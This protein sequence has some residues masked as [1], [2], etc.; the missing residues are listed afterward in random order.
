[1]LELRLDAEGCEKSQ[2]DATSLGQPQGIEKLR[3]YAAK[4]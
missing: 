2:T 4:V 1:M 3:R